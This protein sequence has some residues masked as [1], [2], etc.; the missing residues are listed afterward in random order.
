MFSFFQFCSVS[1]CDVN[2]VLSRLDPVSNLQL[3]S[4][5]YIEDYCLVASS[6]HTADTDKTRQFCLV[7]VSGVNYAYDY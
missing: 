7:C 3:F 1:K 4:L 5:K 2:L 6:V